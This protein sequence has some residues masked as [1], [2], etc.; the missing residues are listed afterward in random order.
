M[1]SPGV[2]D[3][4][5]SARATSRKANAG[6][7]S[8]L[9]CNAER[10][11]EEWTRSRSCRTVSD[12]VVGRVFSDTRLWASFRASTMGSKLIQNNAAKT[13]A[14]PEWQ[15]DH[16]QTRTPL[17]QEKGGSTNPHGRLGQ[18]GLFLTK[19]RAQTARKSFAPGSTS[20]GGFLQRTR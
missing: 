11:N 18:R 20:A 1:V 3:W 7:L 14:F 12:S 5:V 17:E 15:G 19:P 8:L 10:T 16:C 13:P 6:R 2:C 9:R 4:S